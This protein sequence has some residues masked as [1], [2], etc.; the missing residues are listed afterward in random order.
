MIQLKFTK[1]NNFII[2]KKI[3]LIKLTNYINI[4]LFIF[5]IRQ[6]STK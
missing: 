4:N 5:K 2:N 6:I 3:S 1:L